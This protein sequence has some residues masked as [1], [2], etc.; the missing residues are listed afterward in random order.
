MKGFTLIEL[1]VVVLIIGILSA[2]ALPQYQKAVEKSRIMAL[3]P[4]LRT[5]KDSLERYYLANGIYPADSVTDLDIDI[6]G[7]T[8]AGAGKILCDGYCFNYTGG[9][10]AVPEPRIVAMIKPE[11]CDLEYTSTTALTWFLDYSSTPNKRK[12]ISKISG[13]CEFLTGFTTK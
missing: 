5:L 8:I 6:A 2:V 9:I 4:N 11:N 10:P 7:C 3:M 13:V 12:C 1:L